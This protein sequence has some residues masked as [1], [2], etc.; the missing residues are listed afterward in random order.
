[1]SG[2]ARPEHPDGANERVVPCG[3]LFACLPAVAQPV[4]IRTTT[5][6]DGRGHVLKNRDLLIEGGRIA[7]I[8]E[9]SGAPSY[10]LAGL[11]LLPGF[12]DTHVHLA[13][14]FNKDNRLD[15]GGDGSKETPQESALYAEGNAYA[16]LLGGFTTVQSLGSPVDVPLRNLIQAGI[17][18]GPRILTSWSA[19]NETSG[20]PDQI[21]AYA[22]KMKSEGA[23]VIKLFATKS[24]RDGGAQSMTDAQI[25]AAN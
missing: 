5:I 20:T 4:R 11:T 7:A 24:I 25:Q 2:K 23:D 14:H 21:R 8:V 18:P 13:W 9:Q 17:I 16:T 6:V 12:I 15:L 1:M 10:D 3:L 19:I 22:R